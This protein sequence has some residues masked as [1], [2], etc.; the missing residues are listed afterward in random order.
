MNSRQF[1]AWLP[2]L[3]RVCRLGLLKAASANPS[4]PGAIPSTR[5]E[6][7]TRKNPTS[8]LKAASR[9]VHWTTIFTLSEG[10]P[11]TNKTS[12]KSSNWLIW[13]VPVQEVSWSEKEKLAASWLTNN[14]TDSRESL[15]LA[16]L[17]LAAALTGARKLLGEDG[18]RGVTRG[19]T[20]GVVGASIDGA[21][22]I[23]VWSTP[24]RLEPS[25]RSI[26][27]SIGKSTYAFCLDV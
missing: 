3:K 20:S 5:P 2:E 1:P 26:G 21:V 22:A 25:S 17:S 16:K 19:V 6:A 23:K 8:L 10:L 14:G 18:V 24:K 4:S 9:T 27:G 12:P 15:W 11:G 13:G 7:S